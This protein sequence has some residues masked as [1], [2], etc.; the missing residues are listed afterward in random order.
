VG[1]STPTFFFKLV[2]LEFV[3]GN[4]PP[5]LLGRACH[6]GKRSSPLLQSSGCPALF[7]TCPFF[8]LLVYYSVLF[9]YLFILQGWGHSVQ[10]SM[11]IFLGGGCGRTMCCLLLTCGSAK[12]GQSPW[13]EV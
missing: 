7:A 1:A 3:W 13:L 8:Q 10:W 4:S 12:W 2:Y 6:M 9:I 5:P 11:L